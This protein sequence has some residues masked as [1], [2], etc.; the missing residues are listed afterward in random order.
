MNQS[1]EIL[2]E[3]NGADWQAV[4]SLPFPQAQHHVG[5]YVHLVNIE[6]FSTLSQASKGNRVTL[7][8]HLEHEEVKIFPDNWGERAGKYYATYH[9]KILNVKD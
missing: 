9:L 8:V 3:F 5:Y 2:V 1:F 7:N 4:D 6:E